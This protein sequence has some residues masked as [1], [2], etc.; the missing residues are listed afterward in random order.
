MGGV[1]ESVPRRHDFCRSTLEQ[2]AAA[3]S[4]RRRHMAQCRPQ[5]ALALIPHAWQ[6]SAPTP[7]AAVRTIFRL[8]VR[9]TGFQISA[10]PQIHCSSARRQCS[11]G[12]PAISWRGLP[13]A[14]WCQTSQTVN[15]EDT[16]RASVTTTCIRFSTTK[17]TDQE[18]E[19][20]ND[21]V[22]PS[23]Q[24]ESGGRAPVG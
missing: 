15:R 23:L 10:H 4:R 5:D 8:T 20:F 19:P 16:F 13:G 17:F 3:R 24:T 22:T 6:K 18:F 1:A 2:G 7:D 9:T 14:S 21:L 11:E 12:A